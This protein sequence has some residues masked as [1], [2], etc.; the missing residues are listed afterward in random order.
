MH[1]V[2]NVAGAPIPLAKWQVKALEQF[3]DEDEKEAIDG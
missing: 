2:P 3:Q 1:Y